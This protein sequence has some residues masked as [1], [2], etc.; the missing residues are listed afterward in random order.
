MTIRAVIWDL[1]GVLV[2]TEDGAP[3]Q[4]LAAR[5]GM[6][7]NDLEKLV[8]T[9]ASGDRAQLG[10]IDAQQHWQ[11]LRAQLDFTEAEMDAFKRQF[12]QGDALDWELVEYIRSLRER[13]KTA[14]LS[15]AFSNLRT[16]ITEEW[17]FADAFDTMVISAEVGLVK[18]DA[19]IYRLVL[20]RLQ[21]AP[22]QAVFVDDFLH[23]VE[24]ARAVGLHAV[25][26]R[27]SEQ[28]RIELEQILL[29]ENAH[30]R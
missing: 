5:L 8:F 1:G 19:R 14:L 22:A 11:N 29:G 27:S 13:Y 26:F 23:N 24:G 18:P 21:L 25:H 28:A 12:W 17:K 6:T 16:V 4:A 10:E 2:R 7:R 20:D 30:E 15:N 9:G 3:R